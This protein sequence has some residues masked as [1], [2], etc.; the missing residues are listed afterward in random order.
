[1]ERYLIF[2]AIHPDGAFF[3]GLTSKNLDDAI[4]EYRLCYYGSGGHTSVTALSRYAIATKVNPLD[5]EYETIVEMPDLFNALEFK[6]SLIRTHPE[7]LNIKLRGG[8]NN[9]NC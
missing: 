1:M 2:K 3:Y 7:C 8:K 9:G 4:N 5:W 6:R